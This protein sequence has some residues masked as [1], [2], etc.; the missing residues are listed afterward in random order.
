M[1]LSLL[2]NTVKYLKPVQ[3]YGRIQHY[4]YRPNLPSLSVSSIHLSDN[5]FIPP[6]R[7]KRSLGSPARFRFLNQ[8]YDILKASDWNNPA[9]DKLW[10]YNL[11]YFDYLNEEDSEKKNGIHQQ[12]IERWIDENL[13]FAGNGWES[14]PLS[15]RIVNWIKFFLTGN[16]PTKKMINSLYLQTW[17]LRRRLEFH[18]L[19]N[20]LFANAK[21]LIFAGLF[22]NGSDAKKWFYKG[23][24]IYQKEIEEQIFDDGG[25][26]ERSPMYHSIILE[27]LL[28][29]FNIFQAYNFGNNG[30]SQVGKVTKNKIEKMRFWLKVMCHPDRQISFFNDAALGIAPELIKI[31]EYALRLGFS[32][33]DFPLKGITSLPDSGYVRL[34]QKNVVLIADVGKIGPDYLTGHAHADTLS[35]EFSYREKRVFINSGI[36]CYGNSM[37]RLLQR[38]TASHNTLMIDGKDS[39]EVWGSFRVARRAY[40]LEMKTNNRRGDSLRLM[41][42]HNGYQRL[43]G[44]PIHY[45]EWVLTENSLEIRDRISGDYSEAMAFYH[46][47]PGWA[48]DTCDK[49]IFSDDISMFYETDA[50]VFIEKQHYY[51]EF[52][53][54]IPNECLV[55]EPVR[56]EY[57]IKFKWD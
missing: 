27:D 43:K 55:I 34:Q 2:W 10:L 50:G 23:L 25:H 45:R 24:N 52:G 36:S 47:Y 31:E 19:G 17:Y 9:T 37:E 14:Y 5:T 28:D 38:S 1:F 22:F 57:Y 13:P 21:A 39:S 49:R 15:L 42:A 30:V 11:H 54:V 7:K 44:K 12:I 4:L 46:L 32:A 6:I 16:C 35:F 3:I 53:R 26:F 48:I 18:L 33:I 40:P 29:I 41:C 8:E 51:P 20:H 56:N